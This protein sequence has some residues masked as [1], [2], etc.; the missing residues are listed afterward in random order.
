VKSI[1]ILALIFPLLIICSNLVLAIPDPLTV[2]TKAISSI[3]SSSAQGG[4]DIALPPLSIASSSAQGGG[5]GTDGNGVDVTQRGVCWNTA[6]SPTTGDSC[7]NDGSGTGAF[8]SSITGLSASTTYYVRAY[9]VN[10]NPAPLAY[11]VNANPAPSYGANVSFTTAAAGP[12]LGVGA[13]ISFMLLLAGV[14]MYRIRKQ[15]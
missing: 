6:G 13:I 4:G 14:A 10:A 7:T 5:D 11:G 9:G 15:S 3:A 2:T 1:K 12:T 8:S